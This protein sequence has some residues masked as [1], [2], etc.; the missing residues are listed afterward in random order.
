M[1][2]ALYANGKKTFVFVTETNGLVT[3]E[4]MFEGANYERDEHNGRCYELVMT[5]AMSGQ[6]ARESALVKRRISAAD[7]NTILGLAKDAV[8]KANNVEIHNVISLRGTDWDAESQRV[9]EETSKALSK[10]SEMFLEGAA[11]PEEQQAAEPQPEPKSESKEQQLQAELDNVAAV[12]RGYAA[13]AFK[14]YKAAVDQLGDDS[15]TAIRKQG[16]LAALTDVMEEL[17]IEWHLNKFYF[18]FGSAKQFPYG[19]GEYVVVIAQNIKEAARRYRRKYPNPY[20]DE[21]LNCADYYSQK[22]WDERISKYYEG[23]E[24]AK[25][26]E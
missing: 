9:H 1:K 10:L 22:E 5:R 7:Y 16:E 25:I 6:N 20:D 14:L 26:I 4:F 13:E 19:R 12:L 11:E 24:P 23:K 15:N 17:G 18:T 21:I 2:K 3:T 8:E